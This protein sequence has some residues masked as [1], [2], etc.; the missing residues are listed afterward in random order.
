MGCEYDRWP[1]EGV[2][3]CTVLASYHHSKRAGAHRAVEIAAGRRCRRSNARPASEEF[4]R[5]LLAADRLWRPL[6]PA[7]R[8]FLEIRRSDFVT[9]Q[10]E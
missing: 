10:R 5:D 8:H 1:N 7:F 4:A 9:F 2:S 3:G 6:T